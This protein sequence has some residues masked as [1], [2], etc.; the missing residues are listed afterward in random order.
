ML[1]VA[2]LCTEQGHGNLVICKKVSLLLSAMNRRFLGVLLLCDGLQGRFS[3]SLDENEWLALV[4]KSN[5][6]VTA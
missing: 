4:P 1:P 3:R 2:G 5:C 6:A